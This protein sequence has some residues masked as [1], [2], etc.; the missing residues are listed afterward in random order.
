[1]LQRIEGIVLRTVRYND[2]TIIAHLYTRQIGRAS[3]RVA[4]P[5][6]RKASVKSVLFQPLALLEL[7]S[8]V[9]PTTAIYS[10]REAKSA[11]PFTSIPYDPVKA[12]VA[13]FLSEFLSR[14]V[15]EE[16]TEN[17]PLYT[18]LRHSI[19]WLDMCRGSVANFHLVFLMRFSRFLGLYPNLDDYHR[20][21]YFDLLNA[22]FTPTRPTLHL[23]FL[24]PEEASRISRLMRM[25]YDTMHL[26]AMNRN[27][28][29]RCLHIMNEYYRLHL[30]DFPELK[31]LEVLRELFN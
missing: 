31:S 9:R 10:V 14:T 23:S 22:C 30:P 18:Y 13:L 1:M 29:N 27:E 24:E 6:S 2:R 12:A 8:D 25:N 28:R 5:R 4:I 17:V 19:L 7:E 21:D 3:F 15:R 26:F 11:Y 16:G 20:D